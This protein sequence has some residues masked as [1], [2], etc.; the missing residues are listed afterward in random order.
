MHYCGSF[1]C[2]LNTYK[3]CHVRKVTKT[4][5]SPT[6]GEQHPFKQYINCGTTYV[7]YVIQCTSCHVQYVGCTTRPLR[8]KVGEQYYEE[9]NMNAKNMCLSTSEAYTIVKCH[10]LFFCRIERLQI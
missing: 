7:I 1:H 3:Y 6:T 10:L 9:V 8:T 4:V 5:P 2:D